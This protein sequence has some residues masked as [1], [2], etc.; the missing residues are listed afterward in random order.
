M[1]FHKLDEI[2]S[3]RKGTL[4]MTD[5]CTMYNTHFTLKQ[6]EEEEEEILWTTHTKSYTN[7]SSLSLPLSL[8][9]SL[10]LTHT[11]SILRN[12]S[13]GNHIGKVDSLDHPLITACPNRDFLPF[14]SSSILRFLSVTFKEKTYSGIKYFY[15][16]NEDKPYWL[17]ALVKRINPPSWTD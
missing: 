4:Q 5:K 13:R 10:S 1:F 6:K 16:C 3:V 12:T 15:L 14:V 17:L 7:T 11:P 2:F 8:S 9:L